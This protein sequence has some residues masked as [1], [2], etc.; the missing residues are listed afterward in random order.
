MKHN[1]FAAPSNCNNDT[2][3]ARGAA[4]RFKTDAFATD[5]QLVVESCYRYSEPTAQCRQSMPIS[6][7]RWS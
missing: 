6:P 7:N 1:P 2:G 5:V 4:A 3:F